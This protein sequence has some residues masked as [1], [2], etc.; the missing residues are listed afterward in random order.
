[1][2]SSD[3]ISNNSSSGHSHSKGARFGRIDSMSP[4]S[5]VMAKQCPA[6]VKY[7]F[8]ILDGFS[9]CLCGQGCHPVSLVV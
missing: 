1:M 5:V 8:C 3:V 2:L 9:I 6:M 7:L 4:V